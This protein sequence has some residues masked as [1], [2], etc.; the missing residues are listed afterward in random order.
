MHFVAKNGGRIETGT[1]WACGVGFG[2]YVGEHV[3][4]DATLEYR[5]EFE[6]DG[7][8]G[9]VTD[10]HGD[11][12]LDQ[13]TSVDSIVTLFNLYWDFGEHY[14]FT[15]YVG[16]GIG[17]AHNEIES[18]FTHQGY[19]TYGD[20]SW[21]FA[22]ALMAGASVPISPDLL[23]DFGYR[24][25]NFGDVSTQSLG[26]CSPPSVVDEFTTPVRVADMDAHEIRLGFRYNFY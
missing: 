22:W 12:A 11:P 24:Y 16:A 5:G 13:Y 3:R 15:P 10:V 25:V 4:V 19:E 18:S 1:G 7:I 9:L 20:E 2:H 17:F 8:R 23:F 6:I 14:G 21:D 26:C